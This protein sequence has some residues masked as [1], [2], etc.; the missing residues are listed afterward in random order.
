MPAPYASPRDLALARA[1]SLEEEAAAIR[2][3]YVNPRNE[4]EE[5]AQQIEYVNH[6]LRWSANKLRDEAT[7]IH[8]WGDGNFGFIIDRFAKMVRGEI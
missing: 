1:E 3:A 8:H 4:E 6:V 5:E 7:L 2:R